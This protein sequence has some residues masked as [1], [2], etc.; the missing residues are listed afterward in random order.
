ML[1]DLEIE[2]STNGTNFNKV[3]TQLAL[4]NNG[5]DVTYNWLDVNPAAGNNFYRI[6]SIENSG[7][8]KYS[9]IAKVNI[10]KLAPA[11]TVYPNPVT[12]KQ[13]SVQFIACDKGLYNIKLINNMGQS[14]YTASINHTGGSATQSITLE[15]IAAGN[16][17]LKVI[18]P[19]QSN[20]LLKV[21]IAN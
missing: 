1:F 21:N 3:G 13:M 12:G 20:I 19:D 15:G 8:V 4:A 17:Y 5:S 6:R 10:G 7:M 16:Y 11:I 18:K 9:S 14:V 2:K